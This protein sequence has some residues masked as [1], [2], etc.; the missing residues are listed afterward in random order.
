MNDETKTQ[1]ETETGALDENG[2]LKDTGP[3]PEVEEVLTPE[4]DP[5]A[6]PQKR[7]GR[8]PGKKPTMGAESVTGGAQPSKAG[9]PKA[10]AKR[11]AFS[12]SDVAAMGKQLV[13]I[14][15]LIVQFTGIP[16][17]QISNDEGQML[18]QSVINIS[19][20]YDLQIDGKTGAAIQLLAT[21]AMIYGPRAFHYRGR[22][23]QQQQPM[24]KQPQQAAQ[25]PSNVETPAN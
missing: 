2:F 25:G 20:Q 10:S 16:E 24:Q 8:P 4:I 17:M 3:A 5:T 12:A 18:A 15:L 1:N 21:A 23:S 7:R 19:E 14:H 22:M 13:G 6:P 11:A 9:R